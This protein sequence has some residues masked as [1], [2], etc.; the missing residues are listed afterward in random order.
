VTRHSFWPG[1]IAWGGSSMMVDGGE[2]VANV[3]QSNEEH[4]R[5]VGGEK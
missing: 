1:Q 3:E 2:A 4:D 5:T